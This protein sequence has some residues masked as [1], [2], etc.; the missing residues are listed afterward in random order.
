VKGFLVAGT[1]SGVGKTT[2]T[3]GLISAL[4]RRGLTV[5]PFKVGP[6]YIDTSYHA[7]AAGRAS[8][9]LDLW[10]TSPAV[11]RALY[12][13]AMRQAQVAVVEG[14]MGLFDGRLGGQGEASS[15]HVGREVGLPVVLV[16]DAAKISWSAGALVLG[17][18]SFD[19]HLKL[20][21]VILNRVGG[22]RHAAELTASIEGRAGVPVLGWLPRDPRL[23]VPER[24]LG[25]IPTAEGSVAD[26]YFQAA[27]QGVATGVDLERL[28]AL[29]DTTPPREQA[30]DLFPS[31]PA[32]PQAA[33]AVAH[34]RAF[35]FYYQ[36]SLDLLEAWGAE[37]VPFSPLEDPNLPEGVGGMFIGG[38][39]PELF[40]RELSANAS[41]LASLRTAAERD[42]ALYAECGGLMLLGRSL[43]DAEGQRHQMAGLVPLDSSL[44]GPRLT[45]GYR[46]ATVARGSLLLE[47]GETV[48]AHEF[49]WSALER[50]APPSTAAYLVDGEVEGYASGNTLASY[51]HLHLAA[52]PDGLLAR[53]FVARA[54]AVPEPTYAS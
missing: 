29:A 46:E 8:R 47:S 10:L 30:Y 26:T 4:R 31:N 11:M 41:L 6:D 53:R 50:P 51:L 28:L 27:E 45:I 5:Q 12:C 24:Y 39:F 38:G 40:A 19:P 13:R 54:T 37:L 7:R 20:V 52:L 49:H 22:P 25:L 15:A 14:V 18:R 16:V 44:G 43:V 32:R 21:G 34:D 2:I 48:R 9:N 36:D 1:A 17:Y 23:A 42:L 35:S 33:I 3:V